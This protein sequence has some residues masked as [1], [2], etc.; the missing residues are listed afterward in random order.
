MTLILEIKEHPDGYCTLRI[1]GRGQ[2]TPQESA[3][4]NHVLETFQ[5]ATKTWAEQ[6]NCAREMKGYVK[7]TDLPVV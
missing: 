7:E 5:T 2:T 1:V 4:V 3:L 6:H